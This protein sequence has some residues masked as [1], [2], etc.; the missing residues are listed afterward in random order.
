MVSYRT[1]IGHTPTAVELYK[2]TYGKSPSGDMKLI[3]I[4]CLE[5]WFTKSVI[6]AQKF[7]SDKVIKAF[8]DVTQ[9]RFKKYLINKLELSNVYWD[10]IK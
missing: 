8:K 4:C 7:F 3:F 10:R 2:K 1:I 6:Y 5:R 9:Q